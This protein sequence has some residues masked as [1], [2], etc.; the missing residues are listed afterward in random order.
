[1]WNSLNTRGWILLSKSNTEKSFPWEAEPSEARPT[2]LYVGTEKTCSL[3]RTSSS[4]SS[5][6]ISPLIIRGQ[7]ATNGVFCW[8]PPFAPCWHKLT[9]NG[10]FYRS[11]QRLF[12]VSGGESNSTSSLVGA[13][14]DHHHRIPRRQCKLEESWCRVLM[15]LTLTCSLPSN[16]LVSQSLSLLTTTTTIGRN[17]P[18]NTTAEMNFWTESLVNVP[19]VERHNIKWSLYLEWRTKGVEGVLAVIV[20][21]GS[22]P[23]PPTDRQTDRIEIIL[24]DDFG[25]ISGLRSGGCY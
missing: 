25:Y 19:D 21:P 1:M 2:K 7:V 16:S 18:E 3:L 4:S 10:I 15:W 14:A 23:P 13:D 20:C 9:W 11:S 12:I 22:L 24:R 17:S 5:R 8:P 6:T